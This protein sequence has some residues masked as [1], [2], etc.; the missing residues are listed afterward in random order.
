MVVDSCI[1]AK[2][3]TSI[4]MEYLEAMGVEIQR[5]VKLVVVTHW[6]DDHIRGIAQ[7]V[8]RA[9]RARFAC[10]AALNCREF[11]TIFAA[12]RNIQCV[13]HTSGTAEFADIMDIFEARSTKE[14]A[15]PV[16][17]WAQDGCRLYHGQTV[18]VWA[19]SPSGRTITEAMQNIGAA[20]PTVGN[21]KRRFTVQ[22]PNELAVALLVKTPAVNLLLGADLE[23]GRDAQRGWQAVL[24][25]NLRPQEP[26]QVFKV[27]HH[28][29]E[30]ADM[31]GIWN[32][33]L[34]E[35]PIACLTPYVRGPKPLPAEEDIARIKK[36]TSR[37]YTTFWPIKKS[38]AKRNPA[39]ERTVREITSNHNA[40]RKEP[41][42]IRVRVP[43]A[44]NTAGTAI[45]LFNGAKRI[46]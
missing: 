21:P 37:L 4:A 20:I 16:I 14:N 26:A 34:T 7:L 2:K 22:N 38:P 36:K 18:E 27:A 24:A 45:Q 43:I 25:S 15:T 41:G 13:E 40:T 39:V 35:E 12:D 33:L 32:N 11:F 1:N 5:Q 8:R 31:D 17:Q 6:H 28:G 19:L 42:H 44:G 9:D 30:N 10:S 3:T 29:S 46:E 23:E